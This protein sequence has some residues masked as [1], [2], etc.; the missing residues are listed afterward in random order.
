MILSAMTEPQLI[1]E[2]RRLYDD[3]RVEDAFALSRSAVRLFPDSSELL[4]LLGDL[5][6]LSE[7]ETPLEDSLASYER[8]ARLDPE[9]YEPHE[10]IG[11]VCDLLEDYPRAEAAFRRAVEL[12]GAAD[13]YAGLAR[14][15][16]QR[17]HPQSEVVALLD[18]CPFAQAPAVQKVRDEV[19]GGE[20]SPD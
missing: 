6:Q 3:S 14:V 1:D 4:C 13:S 17:G 18:G 16:A 7:T 15:L 5:S 12:G 8:A 2:V 10:S 20:W 11:F 9:W 19:A